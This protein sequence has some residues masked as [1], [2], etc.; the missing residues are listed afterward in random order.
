MNIGFFFGPLISHGSRDQL[1]ARME[2]RFKPGKS[3][4][5]SYQPISENIRP[6]PERTDLVDPGNYFFT[7][8]SRS[9]RN[10]EPYGVGLGATVFPARFNL[11]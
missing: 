6:I 10:R 7:L 9:L 4:I 2:C 3:M 8:G 5:N 11:R 1:T